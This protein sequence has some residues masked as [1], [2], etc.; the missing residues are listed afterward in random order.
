VNEETKLSLNKEFSDDKCQRL[1]VYIRPQA[2]LCKW[3]FI[4][5]I[6]AKANE[7]E[8]LPRLLR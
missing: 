3:V 8:T 1:H 4:E 2:E 6:L 7:K 5:E